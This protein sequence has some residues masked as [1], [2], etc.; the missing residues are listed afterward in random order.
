MCLAVSLAFVPSAEAAGPR[1]G[2]AV[3]NGTPVSA[4]EVPWQALIM[5]GRG[6]QQA[7]CSGA[8]ISPTTIA[9]VAHCL[10]G[11]GAGDVKA[12]LGVSRMSEARPGQALPIAGLVVHPGYDPQ[13]LANDI[14]LIQLATPVDLAAGDGRL[15]ALPF[16]L[17]PATWPAAGTPATISGWGAT[18]TDGKESDQL[19][20]GDVQVLA[21]P[22]AA[23][24]QYGPA[25]NASSLICGGLPSGAVDTCQGDS[26]GPFTVSVNGNPVLAGLTSNGVECASAVYPGLY[27]RLTTFLP[28]IQQ[29]TDVGG[30]AARPASPGH[31]RAECREDAGE[32]GIA[33]RTRLRIDRVDG[34]RSAWRGHLPDDRLDLC[35]LRAA[36]RGAGHLHGAGHRPMGHRSGRCI[37]TGDGRDLPGSAR[38]LGHRAHRR[39]MAGAAGGSQGGAVEPRAACTV[40]GPRVRL[41]RT[42]TCTLIV[43]AQGKR[44]VAVI[45]VV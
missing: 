8:L 19:L 9:S 18:V 38:R 43:A 39:R 30:R 7:L 10:Q 17:D 6:G 33:G 4:A 24:G 31:C 1:S 20:R 11:V 25:F 35:S 22:N 45:N 28:W 37:R 41:N 3:V 13:S 26:G 5:V 12:W 36:G 40:K 27:T 16:G 29:S 42:G 21:A 32:L 15:I 44:R 14:A 34:D 2:P 23:C